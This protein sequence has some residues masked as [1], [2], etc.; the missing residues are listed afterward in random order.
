[1]NFEGIDNALPEDVGR[2]ILSFL[3]TPTLVQKKAVCRS[4]RVIL[5]NTIV[6][7]ASTPTPFQSK[8]ELKEAV[9][10]YSRYN[11]VDAEEF[12]QTYGWPIDRWNVS[13]V[14]DFSD[15]FYNNQSF[16]ENIRNFTVNLANIRFRRNSNF[17]TTLRVTISTA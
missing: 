8:A 6:Q 2:Y 11:L 3:D 4:W 1:M 16:N 14:E 17:F 12:A 7:K 13:R 15:L 10:K 9:Y 5:P